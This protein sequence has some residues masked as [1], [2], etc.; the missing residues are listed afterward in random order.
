M[1]E[2]GIVNRDIARELGRMGHLDG[3]MITDAGFAIPNNIPCI[4]LSIAVNKPTALEVLE[5]LL[6]HYSVEKAIISNATREVSPSRY[7]AF[8]DML[9]GIEIGHVSQEEL[10]ELVKGVKFVIRTGDFTANS[11]V[12]LVSGGGTR[13]YCEK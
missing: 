8:A 13:W 7:N 9:K 3:M 5:E 4:D 12:L 10:R 1:Q 2:T 6:K 11:N